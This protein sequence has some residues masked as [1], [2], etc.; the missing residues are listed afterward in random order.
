MWQECGRVWDI[1]FEKCLSTMKAQF[2]LL[3][4]RSLA[5]NNV[6]KKEDIG[7]SAHDFQ[8]GI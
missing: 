8:K 6:E 7:G 4:G 3:C 1:K 5:D 2:N